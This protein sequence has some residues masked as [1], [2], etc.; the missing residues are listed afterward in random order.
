M[1]NWLKKLMTSILE[2]LL[3]KQII[4]L[5]SKILKTKYLVIT[6]LAATTALTSVEIRY[7]TLVIQSKKT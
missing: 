3:E 7:Q 6:N 2:D 4:M 5:R 1:M